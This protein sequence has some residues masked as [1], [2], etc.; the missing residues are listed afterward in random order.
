MQPTRTQKRWSGRFRTAG[1]LLSLIGA[2]AIADTLVGL[3]SPQSSTSVFANETVPLA[4]GIVSGGL[5]GYLYYLG[6]RWSR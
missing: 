2:V 5:G 3:A 4:V 1:A 6:R